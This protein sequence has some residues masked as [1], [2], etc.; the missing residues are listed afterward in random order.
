MDSLRTAALLCVFA[1]AAGATPDPCAQAAIHHGKA[2][3]LMARAA[4]TSN[5]VRLAMLAWDVGEE[6]ELA[7]QLDPDNVDVRV[8]LVRYYTMT[9]GIVGGSDEKASEQA[10][11]IAKRDAALG[12]FANGYIAYRDKELG[13]ARRELTDALALATTAK[14]KVLILTWLGWL[15]QES[16]QYPTAFDA[17]RRMLEADPAQLQA[18]YEIGRTSAF[19]GCELERGENALVRYIGAKRSPEMPTVGEARYYLALVY[20]KRGNLVAARREIRKADA[21]VPGVTEARKRLD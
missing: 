9:P 18:L 1:F 11:E 8:D 13:L 16:Q 17:F 3:A 21:S 2:R 4:R 7:L 12:H 14:T 19:C 20:E 5:P 15:S 10:K 6:L